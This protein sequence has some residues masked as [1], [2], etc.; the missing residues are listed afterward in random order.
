MA[1]ASN[2]T[3]VGKVH[4][5]EDMQGVDQPGTFTTFDDDTA[6][7]TGN[8]KVTPEQITAHYINFLGKDDKDIASFA[9]S[10][11]AALLGAR[12]FIDDNK[13]IAG[14]TAQSVIPNNAQFNMDGAKLKDLL[15]PFAGKLDSLRE[16]VAKMNEAL[17]GN[18]AMNRATGQVRTMGRTLPID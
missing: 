16:A 1:Q 10:G 18:N 3:N 7:F 5:R 2:I 6:I 17:E 11:D 4:S 13:Q 15:R 14:L 12:T 8:G 9:K